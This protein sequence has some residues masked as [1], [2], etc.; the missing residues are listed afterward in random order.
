MIGYIYKI[1][2]ICLRQLGKKILHNDILQLNIYAFKE[3]ID[4]LLK[5]NWLFG[6]VSSYKTLKRELYIQNKGNYN[7]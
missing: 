4:E 6:K 2:N 5:H 3:D 1:T 7:L